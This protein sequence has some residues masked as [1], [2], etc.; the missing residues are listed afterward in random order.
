MPPSTAAAPPCRARLLGLRA[1]IRAGRHTGPT[2]GLAP[3]WVQANVVILPAAA[4]ADFAEFCRRNARACPLLD[5]TAARRSASGSST[6]VR[7]ARPTCR[8]TASSATAWPIRSSRP[9]S[10]ALWRDDLV[11]VSPRLFVHL[12]A[13]A[14]GR[15]SAGAASGSRHQRADVSDERSPA[16]R[17]ADLPVRWS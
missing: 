3:G 4:A 17:P 5:Q 7:S 12:R 9:T 2:A 14:G 15:R 8:V 13:C 1:E 10:A 6:G 11:G 16:S